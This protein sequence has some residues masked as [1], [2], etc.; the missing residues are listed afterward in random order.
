MRWKQISLLN[1]SSG[2]LSWNDMIN[3]GYLL[4]DPFISL[5][6]FHRQLQELGLTKN[7]MNNID[8][9]CIYFSFCLGPEIFIVPVCP[10]VIFQ[11]LCVLSMC[12]S[13]CFTSCLQ[14]CLNCHM[15]CCVL[16]KCVLHIHT[17][18][19]TGLLLRTANQTCL[20]RTLASNQAQNRMVI[21]ASQLHESTSKFKSLEHQ[22]TSHNPN[23]KTTIDSSIS[24]E[25]TL[26]TYS[27]KMCLQF[28]HNLGCGWW[29][30]NT[31]G[32][33]CLLPSLVCKYVTLI[34]CVQFASL[35]QVFGALCFHCSLFP[36]SSNVMYRPVTTH[37]ITC[38][39]GFMN[40]NLQ[41]KG[42]YT[43]DDIDTSQI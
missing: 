30:G 22:I 10:S 25:A 41:S 39:H 24:R 7:L 4:V 34:F 32:L 17:I 12:F 36:I 21:L 9:F 15:G 26:S 11:V 43:V 5:C 1:Q 8:L 33:F 37:V 27:T 16:D 23:L 35:I 19:F 2:G 18:L 31:S 14:S 38:G 28:V 6:F 13:L 3:I 20:E 29:C 40:N 42:L